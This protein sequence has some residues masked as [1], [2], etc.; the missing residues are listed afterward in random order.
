MSEWGAVGSGVT[1]C[2]VLLMLKT[3]VDLMTTLRISGK[4]VYFSNNCLVVWFGVFLPNR[5]LILLCSFRRF[6]IGLE[7]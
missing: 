4:E 7:D 2:Q 3:P 6:K 1:L 5:L